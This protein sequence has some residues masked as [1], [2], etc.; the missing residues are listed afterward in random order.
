ME[1]LI[2]TYYHETADGEFCQLHFN[3]K[4]E[5]AYLKYYRNQKL[6]FTEEFPG[7]SIRYV[8]DAAENWALGLKKL[9]ENSMG[10]K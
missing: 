4:L 1:K 3:F 7:K 2:S 5:Y 8:E 10:Q 6:F 9:N